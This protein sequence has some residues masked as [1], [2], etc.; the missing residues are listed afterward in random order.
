MKINKDILW[1]DAKKKSKKKNTSSSLSHLFSWIIC[2][3]PGI[4]CTNYKHQIVW[5]EKE[6]CGK[7]DQPFTKPTRSESPC[8]WF[9]LRGRAFRPS[10]FVHASHSLHSLLRMGHVRWYFSTPTLLSSLHIWQL[11]P[12]CYHS[13]RLFST[14]CT[15]CRWWLGRMGEG[16]QE[17]RTA[18]SPQSTSLLLQTGFEVN[19][20]WKQ[21]W[22]KWKQ[23]RLLTQA[24]RLHRGSA[25]GSWAQPPSSAPSV[26][27]ATA[28]STQTITQQFTNS[29][30]GQKHSSNHAL[31]HI[32]RHRRYRLCKESQHQ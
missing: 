23:R 4:K 31:L 6:V 16:V 12:H 25:W 32:Q 8:K 29:Q 3:Q 20:K 1:H 5:E 2:V 18:F 24:A 14:A 26:W 21:S 27:T 22:R 28:T 17:K 13:I 10:S 19:R 11:I 7:L 15:R 30:A 9:H